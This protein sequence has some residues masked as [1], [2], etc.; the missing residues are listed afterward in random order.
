MSLQG[1]RLALPAAR[2]AAC[3]C[4]VAVELS[5]YASVYRTVAQADSVMMCEELPLCRLCV[6]TRG[7]A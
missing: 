5:I 7:E 1:M 4:A 6:V 2:R 3:N